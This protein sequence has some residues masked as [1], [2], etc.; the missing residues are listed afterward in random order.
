MYPIV[1]IIVVLILCF[2]GMAGAAW[3]YDPVRDFEKMKKKKENCIHEWEEMAVVTQR[4]EKGLIQG[5]GSRKK[6]Y[7]CK[8]C[9]SMESREY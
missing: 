5:E 3:V 9:G 2:I 6:M 1:V 8:K 4:N 7:R